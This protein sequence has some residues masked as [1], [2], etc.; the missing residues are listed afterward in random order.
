MSEGQHWRVTSSR[1]VLSDR[2]INVRADSCT[3]PRGAVLDPYYVLSY[4]DWVHVVALTDDDRIVLVRQ[5]RHGAGQVSLELPS[6]GVDPRDPS[7]EAAA[8]RELAEETGY[9]AR[10]FR[11]VGIHSP[12]AATHTNRVHTYLAEGAAPH[13]GQSLDEGEEGMTVCPVTVQEIMSRLGDGSMIQ[14]NHVA[15]MLLA[16]AAA[17]HPLALGATAG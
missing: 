4:P 7:T 9:T 15:S 2:W 12:N 14:L 16:L 8:R 17:R 10:S 11:L 6:G 5:Y 1:I 3:T 13:G